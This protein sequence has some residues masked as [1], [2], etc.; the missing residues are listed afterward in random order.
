ML[1]SRE[2]LIHEQGNY[3]DF[4]GLYCYLENPDRDHSLNTSNFEK[5]LISFKLNGL[6]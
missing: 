5:W 6:F 2:K 3:P 1:Y 4:G